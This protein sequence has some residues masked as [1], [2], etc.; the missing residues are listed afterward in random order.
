MST[1]SDYGSRG[2]CLCELYLHFARLDT[3][4]WYLSPAKH[5]VGTDLSRALLGSVA[6]LLLPKD[7]SVVEG[8]WRCPDCSEL[9]TEVLRHEH[10]CSREVEQQPLTDVH[11]AL[12]TLYL[13]TDQMTTQFQAA[14]KDLTIHPS[15]RWLLAQRQPTRLLMVRDLEWCI[16]QMLCHKTAEEKAQ[17]VFGNDAGL[18]EQLHLCRR[19]GVEF[20]N[21]DS[22][23]RLDGDG[24]AQA[25]SVRCTVCLS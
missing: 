14:G 15:I 4:Q 2:W 23:A 19:K 16:H 25:L 10:L 24:V 21:M 3:A 1:L 12:E 9:M 22:K 17:M 6:M 13:L 11:M 8:Q 20:E 18:V 5:A 7:V